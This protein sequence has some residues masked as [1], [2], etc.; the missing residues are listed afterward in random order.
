MFDLDANPAVI[1]DT[2]A[3][4]PVLTDLLART[5]G[6]RS[7]CHAAPFESAVRA[8]IGQQ[9]SVAAARTVLG[10]LVAA[11]QDG[12]PPCTFPSAAA[13]AALPDDSFAMP[14]R[15]RDSLRA[16]CAR[17]AGCEHDLD[18]D[19]LA[20]I[21][22]VG[23]WTRSLVSMRGLGSPDEF[24]AGDLGLVKAWESHRGVCERVGDARIPRAAWR[25][26]GSYAANLL[27]RSLSL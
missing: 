10:R 1:A 22:G 23:P 7:P 25:P 26:W 16:L 3:A 15:R 19:T 18:A 24:P 21:P 27:W 8:I 17:F 20:G 12:P 5:P 4:D 2:L 9:V 13:L 6:I 11:C 14:R